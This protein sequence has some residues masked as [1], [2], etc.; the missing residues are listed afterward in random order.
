MQQRRLGQRSKLERE[1]IEGQT[2]LFT[3]ILQFYFL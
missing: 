3:S 1:E 2:K